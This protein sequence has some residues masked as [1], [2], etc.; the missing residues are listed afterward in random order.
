MNFYRPFICHESAVHL[1]FLSTQKFLKKWLTSAPLAGAVDLG[2]ALL[3][4]DDLVTV[5]ERLAETAEAYRLLDQKDGCRLWRRARYAA[6]FGQG[7]AWCHALCPELLE[8][9]IRCCGRAACKHLTR[10]E[11]A[12]PR[13]AAWPS[14]SSHASHVIAEI[15]RCIND[16]GEVWT[17][18]ALRSARIRQELRA[19]QDRL[20]STLD[21]LVQTSEL[22]PYLQDA[23]VTQRQGRYVIPVRSEYKGQIDGIVHDQSSSGA[24]LFIEPIKVV[25]QNNAVRELGIAGGTE[26]CVA[27]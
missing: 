8:S 1:R 13:L 14:T 15:G 18:P 16:R 5:Q 9:G 4:S 26:K 10:L 22:K 7:R 23:L 17:A 19:A 2:V 27:S 24:T 25:Q 11:Q 21:R 3:P 12:F 6:L 20:L